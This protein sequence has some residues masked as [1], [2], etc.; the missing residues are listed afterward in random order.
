MNIKDGTKIGSTPL[1]N[2]KNIFPDLL[3]E[4][5]VPKGKWGYVVV[6]N[7]SLNFMWIDTNEVLVVDANTP[8]LIQPERLH[9]V[10]LTGPVNFKVEFY[11]FPDS[12]C[13]SSSSCGCGCSTNEVAPPILTPIIEAS[14]SEVIE[15][16]INQKIKDNE[17]K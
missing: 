15:Q 14:D 16:E 10:I 4:H 13:C 7:G 1:M 6:E 11:E 17:L 9:K 8:L 5:S 2:E 12:G 3:K